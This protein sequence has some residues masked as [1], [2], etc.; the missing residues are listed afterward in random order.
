MPEFERYAASL[1]DLLAGAVYAAW[2]RLEPARI[3]AAV[4][5]APGLSGN[6]VD[7]ERP[8]DDSLTVIRIDRAG[9]EPLA[10]VVSFAAHPITVGGTTILWDAEYIAPL[11]D[12][13]EAAVPGRRVHLHPGLRGRHR[14]VRLVVRRLRGEPAR[15][16]GARPPGARDRRGGARAVPGDRD[17]QPM[18]GWRPA[19]KWL[20][21]RRRRHAYDADEIR[22][23]QAELD[24]A[25][26]AGL[27]RGLGARGA[28]DDLRPD[29]PELLPGRGARMYLD[30]IER[31]D[32][33]A[34][35]EIQAIAVDDIAIVTN[36]F[37]L[38]NGAG[39][40]IKDGSPFG[41]TIAAAYANDYAGYLPES[42]DMDLVEGV[43]LSEI[44]DQDNYRWAY[45]ITNTNVDRGEVDRLIAESTALLERIHA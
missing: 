45:G 4:G 30:M 14:A 42:A 31:A 35:A 7:R 16:R 23:L 15:L 26:A 20:D 13:V 29:V 2:R 11:R 8:V 21:L 37:E 27:A 39:R 40:R 36:P 41:T 43:P 24:G 22:A 17:E 34:R 19:S 18:P 32:E 28:H 1:G 12:T 3:G 10:A 33:P 5:R 44:L 38:F 9:G 6:R 25:P